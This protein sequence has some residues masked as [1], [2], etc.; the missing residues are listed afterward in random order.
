MAFASQTEY[1]EYMSYPSFFQRIADRPVQLPVVFH[2]QYFLHFVPSFRI[3]ICLQLLFYHTIKP[4][5]LHSGDYHDIVILKNNKGT[6][7]HNRF[8]RHGTAVPDLILPN[9]F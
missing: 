9:L 6:A 1:A 2:D 5:D 4:K 8:L 7:V 3:F